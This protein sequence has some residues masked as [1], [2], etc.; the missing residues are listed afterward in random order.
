MNKS[1]PRHW[2][3]LIWMAG[4]PALALADG[5]VTPYAAADIER[6]SNIFYLPKGA[7]P[8][9]KNGPTFAD[10]FLQTRAGVEGVYQV[11]RQR[12]FGTAEFRRFDYNEF[13]QLNHNEQLYDGGLKWK[14][15][16]SVDGLLE[17]KHN[18]RMVLFQDLTGPSSLTLETEN[19]ATASVNVNVTP[20][21]RVESA[22]KDRELNSPRIDVPTLSLRE[23]SIREGLK[24]LGVAN[25]SAGL[26]AEY[27][28]GKY[29]HDTTALNPNYHQTSVAVAATYIA[30]GWTDFNGNLGY[31]RRAD[32]TNSG[33][34]GV[35]GSLAYQHRIT[36]KTSIN[37]KLNRAIN[38]YV[39]TG[40]NEID[41][42]AAVGLNWQATYKIQVRAD[43]SYTNSKFP[44]APNVALATDR[45]DHFQNA[46]VEMTYQVLHWLSIRP[47]ARYQTRHSNSPINEFNANVVGV[48]LIAKQFRPNH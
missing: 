8:I 30:S 23:D 12:F 21:W 16:G 26:E 36:G 45:V 41:T 1:S 46:T 42:S 47:Y 6:N 44:Q 48:E 37:V 39:T 29:S 9:G 27:L 2:L 35:T 31:T 33:L 5:T 20:E 40:G 34:S 7:M 19:D 13:T 32:P 10:T 38:T 3:C 4:A 11:D 18:R 14:L 22:A 25:L 24:Y 28:R 17:Y 43:Y 15:G